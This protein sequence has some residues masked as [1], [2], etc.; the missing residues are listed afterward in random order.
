MKTRIYCTVAMMALMLTMGIGSAKA[1]ITYNL[2]TDN[3]T[4]SC[5]T[6]V[7]GTA[8]VL[9][10][11]N[12]TGDVRVT[13]TLPSPL[14]FVNTGL[15]ETIDFNLGSITTGVTATLFTN[16]NFSLVSV[17]A[18]SKHFDVF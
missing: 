10:H 17:T 2:T 1:D 3:C 13:V 4:G 5:L 6:G 9:L 15:V 14:E 7:V 11:Q 12:G 8:T 16:A 18:G